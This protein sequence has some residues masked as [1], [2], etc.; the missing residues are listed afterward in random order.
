VGIFAGHV[1]VKIGDKYYD[2][3]YGTT[4]PTLKAWED[5]AITFYGLRQL[6]FEFKSK[7][8]EVV[9]IMKVNSTDAEGASDVI[10]YPAIPG[11]FPN[12]Y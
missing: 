5:A 2:P 8:Y 12:D 9:F 3:S 10:R 11:V 7:L 4:A 1:L 6:K